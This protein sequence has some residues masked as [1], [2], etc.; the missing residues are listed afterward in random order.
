MRKTIKVRDLIEM[1]N[2]RNRCS[3]CSEAARSGWNS[4]LEEVLAKTDSYAGFAL[5]KDGEVPRNQKPGITGT[6]PDC[7]FPDDSRRSYVIL[8][9]L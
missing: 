9:R 5:L 3:T 1:V 7:T 6:S 8:P 2:A 4:F